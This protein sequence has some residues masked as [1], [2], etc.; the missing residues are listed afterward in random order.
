MSTLRLVFDDNSYP[1]PKKSLSKFLRNNRSLAEAKSYQVRSSVLSD[2]FEAFVESL[3]G[4]TKISVTK[5]N[6]VDLHILATEFDVDT[7][8]DECAEFPI[9]VR[10]FSD[11]SQQVS[12]LERRVSTCTKTSLKLEESIQSQEGNFEHLR[13]EVQSVVTP[14]REF[15]TDVDAHEEA[16]ETLRSEIRK[17]KL[18]TESVIDSPSVDQQKRS[19]D[20]VKGRLKFCLLNFPMKQRGSLDGILSYL[21]DKHD[22]HLHDAGV[23]IVT[24]KS[25][26]LDRGLC[27]C[28]AHGTDYISQPWFDC[29][30]CH[31]VED[32]GCCDVC[33]RTCHKGHDVIDCGIHSRCYCDCGDGASGVCQCLKPAT[34]EPEYRPKFV[35]DFGSGEFFYSTNEPEQWVCLDFRQIS[36][37]PTHYTLAA[38]WLKSWVIEGS[39]DGANWTELDRQTDTQDFANLRRLAAASFTV[40]HPEESRFIR[41]SQTVE[42]HNGD[43]V[44]LLGAFQCFGT[45]SEYISRND[46]LLYF[47]VIWQL[48]GNLCSKAL[49]GRWFGHQT[50]VT[51]SALTLLGK[52]LSRISH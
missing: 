37:R 23:V 40:A 22:P 5:E 52:R 46:T 39:L 3:N 43:D 41:L 11:L 15:E 25:V 16:L 48:P 27:T 50:A 6:A 2:V 24:T 42:N 32:L 47:A 51:I 33:A 49:S 17:L 26:P 10:E 19:L 1:V 12:R 35:I 45:I 14:A 34:G 38:G 18:Q 4:Q 7:L 28:V 21:A 20:D 44:L 8:A 30:T 13:L 36:V 29:R 31:L 9:S